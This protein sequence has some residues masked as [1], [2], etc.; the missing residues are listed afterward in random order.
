MPH[1]GG[2]ESFVRDIS[3]EFTKLG[4]EVTVITSR[5][6]RSLP[7]EE[8][9]NGV[10]VKRVPLLATILRTPIP[11]GLRSRLDGDFDVVH[12]HTPPPSFA[13]MASRR[14]RSQGV[15]TVVTY[16]CDSDLPSRLSAPVVRFLDRRISSSI[17]TGYSRVIVTTE[18]YASTSANTWRIT[19]DIVPVGAD[20][21][22][23]FPD[24]EDRLRTR[25][26]L[27]IDGNRVALFVG[28]LVRHKG[29]QYLIEAMRHTAAGTRLMIVGDGEFAAR[30]KHTARVRSGSSRVTFVGD[31][32]DSVLPSIYRA[33]DVLVVPS[34]SRL[35]AFG[36]SAIEAMASGTPVVVSDIP[37][38][39]EVIQ[40]GVQGLRAEPMNPPDIAAK[41][42]AI[43]D[44]PELRQ[45]MIEACVVRAREFSSRTVAERLA[46]IYGNVVASNSL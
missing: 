45:T 8:V 26:R 6:D 44:R 34:T 46:A 29:V 17:I 18:T 2:V 36:I 9:V 16:H 5:S 37:G 38:V 23:F 25:R 42:D 7:A 13:Y 39:R 4:H 12:A 31:V 28:R 19:P 1:H 30:L 15:P 14:L 20:T 32:P 27:G 10:T 11:R 24:P 40:D 35:E 41:I 3:A 21:R 43:F 22:R 33:A